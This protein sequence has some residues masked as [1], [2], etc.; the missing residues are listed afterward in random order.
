MIKV[1]KPATFF[2]TKIQQRRYRLTKILVRYTLGMGM[3]F[4]TFLLPLQNVTKSFSRYAMLA[5]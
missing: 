5:I 3:A 4:L 2:Q 1:D